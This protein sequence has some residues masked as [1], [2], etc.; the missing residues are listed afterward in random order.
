[1]SIWK[2]TLI[3]WK[4]FWNQYLKWKVWLLLASV[5]SFSLSS[6]SICCFLSSLEHPWLNARQ[7][8]LHTVWLAPVAP[9]TQHHLPLSSGSCGHCSPELSRKRE[10]YPCHWQETC[11]LLPS[12]DSELRFQPGTDCGEFPNHWA[13][14]RGEMGAFSHILPRVLPL[15]KKKKAF[16]STTQLVE[17]PTQFSKVPA[18][19]QHLLLLFCLISCCVTIGFRLES[20]EKIYMKSLPRCS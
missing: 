3:E 8:L 14:N 19:V 1:M 4:V 10:I 2:D 16:Q 11:K 15:I 17:T 12:R 7:I 18:W 9:L 6:F 13:D 20:C 5:A